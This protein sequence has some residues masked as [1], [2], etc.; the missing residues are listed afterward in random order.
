MGSIYYENDEIRIQQDTNTKKQDTN[1][2][3]Y[4]KIQIFDYWLLGFVWLLLLVT[5]I[6]Q[7]F[8]H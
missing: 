1:K 3:Q 8:G 2:I 7:Q 5:C 6:F 4:I